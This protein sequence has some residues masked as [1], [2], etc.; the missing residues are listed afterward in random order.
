MKQS[1]FTISYLFLTCG[2]I[3]FIFYSFN[4]RQ[5]SFVIGT[6]ATLISTLCLFLCLLINFKSYH[7]SFDAILNSPYKY[8]SF[9]IIIS[10]FVVEFRWKVRL[11]SL[12]MLPVSLLTMT[13]SAFYDVKISTHNVFT[14]NI[15]TYLHVSLLMIS[16]SLI[17]LSFSSSVIYILKNSHLKKHN[18]P[19]NLPALEKITKMIVIPFN[20][21]WVSMTIGILLSVISLEEI[22]NIK[23]KTSLGGVV[24]IIYSF[25]FIRHNFSKNSFMSLAKGTIILFI[26]LIIFFLF[27]SLSPQVAENLGLLYQGGKLC[28]I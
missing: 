22:T 6:F 24:W 23:L 20:I 26:L 1:L 4:K 28:I 7:Y 5:S 15:F 3:S 21:G 14:N 13:L 17:L 16:F 27:T 18:S 2:V 10:Y 12:L 9:L 8:F 19:D 11:L 25:Y